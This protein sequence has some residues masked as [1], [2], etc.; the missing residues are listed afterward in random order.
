MLETWC[1]MCVLYMHYLCSRGPWSTHQNEDTRGAQGMETYQLNNATVAAILKHSSCNE[2]GPC[3]LSCGTT[4]SWPNS[5][6]FSGGGCALLAADVGFQLVSLPLHGAFLLIPL[7][8]GIHGA[9]F[10]F[11]SIKNTELHSSERERER[12]SE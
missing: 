12:E 2:E 3:P 1:H 7:G 9:Q 4:T 11:S 10:Q 5:A 6:G 8:P